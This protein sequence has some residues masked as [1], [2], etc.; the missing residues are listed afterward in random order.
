MVVKKTDEGLADLKEIRLK[1]SL[2]K[3][4]AAT[5]TVTKV[6]DNGDEIYEAKVIWKR[7]KV[8][9][10]NVNVGNIIPEGSVRTS[11]IHL[12]INGEGSVELRLI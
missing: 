8:G 5:E 4:E 9:Q 7:Q 2:V 11:D 1:C 3:K 6:T 10:F 12:Q